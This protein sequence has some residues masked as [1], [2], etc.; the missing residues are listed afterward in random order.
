VTGLDDSNV[1]REKADDV[2][3]QPMSK[4][5]GCFSVA[6][7][8]LPDISLFLMPRM[9]CTY[10]LQYPFFLLSFF[11]VEHAHIPKYSILLRIVMID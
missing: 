2:C 5:K 1:E 4:M 8:F 10:E 11:F 7:L 9:L 3:G 6:F